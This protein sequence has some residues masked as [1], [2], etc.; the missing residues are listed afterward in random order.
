MC[1]IAGGQDGSAG[2]DHALARLQNSEH[3]SGGRCVEG[4]ESPTFRVRFGQCRKRRAGT[5]QFRRGGRRTVACRRDFHAE[6]HHRGARLIQRLHRDHA[7][8]DECLQTGIFAARLSQ[9]LER[10]PQLRLGGAL[11]GR[12]GLHP[13]GGLLPFPCA[14]RNRSECRDGLSSCD[15]VSIAKKHAQEASSNRRRHDVAV[16]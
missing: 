12:R 3:A 6:R 7:L 15:R 5:A 9:I 10:V 16:V 13:R 14:E 8:R 11:G 4:D 2:G 1:E